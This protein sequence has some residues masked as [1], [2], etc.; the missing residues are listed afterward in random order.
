MASAAGGGSKTK[1]QGTLGNSHGQKPDPTSTTVSRCPWSPSPCVTVAKG[2]GGCA[3]PASTMASALAQAWTRCRGGRGGGRHVMCDAGTACAER[4]GK[5]LLWQLAVSDGGVSCTTNT[6]VDSECVRRDARAGSEQLAGNRASGVQRAAAGIASCV[7]RA[8]GA[9]G[10]RRTAGVRGAGSGRERKARAAGSG[11]HR[12]TQRESRGWQI[13]GKGRLGRTGGAACRAYVAAR[14]SQ[15]VCG[16]RQLADTL[17][18]E[19]GRAHTH[20]A[21]ERAAGSGRWVVAGGGQRT[22][23]PV[24]GGCGGRRRTAGAR[25]TRRVRVRMATVKAV[26]RDA[27]AC[28]RGVAG[29]GRQGP[30]SGARA[31]G[32]GGRADDR[33]DDK[34]KPFRALDAL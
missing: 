5:K 22:R 10:A 17:D 1:G 20:H 4:M 9:D 31:A 23:A 19:G 24:V 3:A 21:D 29:T 7:R 28:G 11:Q 6:S 15:V 2:R 27:S 16:Y 13:E 12:R 25:V 33:A 18:A 8:A 14:R 34:Q 32:S 30:G 26:S